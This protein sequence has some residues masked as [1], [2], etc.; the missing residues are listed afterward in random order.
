MKEAALKNFAISTRY[1]CVGVSFWKKLKAWRVATLFKNRPQHRNIVK[2]L[3]LI[4]LKNICERLFFYCYNDL[5]LH[6]PKVSRS[7]LY[8]GVRLQDSSSRS[9]FLFSS[10]HLSY[11]TQTRPE[12]NKLRRIPLMSQLSPYVG[13]FWSF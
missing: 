12:F 8:D 13:Y 11:W 6:G 3:K 1:T 2:F 7:T 10:P 5:L 4:I 9:S